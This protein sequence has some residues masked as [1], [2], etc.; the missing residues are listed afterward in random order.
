MFPFKK[1]IEPLIEQSRKLVE[2][3]KHVGDT[4][5]K[6]EVGTFVGSDLPSSE[7]IIPSRYHYR[8]SNINLG[9]V[10]IPSRR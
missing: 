1:N 3:A 5:L 8:S 2:Q 9:Q 7:P 4:T 10:D 6:K